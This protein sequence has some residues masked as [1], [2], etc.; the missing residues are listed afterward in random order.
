[1]GCLRFRYSFP[2]V[3]GLQRHQKKVLTVIG[4]YGFGCVMVCLVMVVTVFGFRYEYGETLLQ[5]SNLMIRVLVVIIADV[6]IT[7]VAGCL[8]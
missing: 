6:W 2:Y 4:F 1:M 3:G 7:A 8:I 5:V